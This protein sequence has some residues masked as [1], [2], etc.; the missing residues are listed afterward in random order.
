MKKKLL[1]SIAAVVIAA[2]FYNYNLSHSYV[3]GS[4]GGYNGSPTSFGDCGSCHSPGLIGTAPGLIT[5]TVPT[6]G[7]TPGNT[8][9]VSA[10][11]FYPGHTKFGFEISPQSNSGALLGTLSTGGNN[12]VKVIGAGKYITHTPGGT[13][14]PGGSITWTFNWTAPP[15]GSGTVTF[16]GAFNSSNSNGQSS[17]DTILKSSLVVQENT[18]SVPQQLA[19]EFNLRIFPNP[20]IEN[21]SVSLVLGNSDEIS[22]DLSDLRGRSVARLFK[23]EANAG[24]FTKTLGIP[25]NTAKGNYI[26]G[27]KAGESFYQRKIVIQ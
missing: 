25:A 16:Y 10:M 21:I 15:A 13:D 20:A 19:Q 3:S 26:V 6:N 2:M 17:G 18:V 9:S 1:F 7:Y 11:C 14:A 12:D 4:P 8:Y 23:G 22:I 27:V 24:V 5:S